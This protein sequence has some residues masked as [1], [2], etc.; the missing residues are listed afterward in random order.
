[1]HR[2]L[3]STEINYHLLSSCL[4][5]MFSDQVRIVL[6]SE[7]LNVFVAVN[8]FIDIISLRGQGWVAVI[9]LEL[10]SHNKTDIGP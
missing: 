10:F 9:E 8:L 1:M 5:I 4:V 7:L 3:N 2:C 6:I